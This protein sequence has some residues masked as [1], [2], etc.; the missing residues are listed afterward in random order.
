MYTVKDMKIPRPE[1]VDNVVLQRSAVAPASSAARKQ[2]GPGKNNR[3]STV[4]VKASTMTESL[5]VIPNP[6]SRN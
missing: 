4:V 5:S 1:Y 2:L 3:C 6:L